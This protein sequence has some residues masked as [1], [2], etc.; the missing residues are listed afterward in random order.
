MKTLIAVGLAALSLAATSAASADPVHPAGHDRPVHHAV[1]LRTPAVYRSGLD[2]PGY[3]VAA[4]RHGHRGG[5]HYHRGR[6]HFRGAF[7]RPIA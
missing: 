4:Y 6:V 5:R 3:Y 2:R 7:H 1:V